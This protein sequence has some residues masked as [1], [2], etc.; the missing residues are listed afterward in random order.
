MR[1]ADMCQMAPAKGVCNEGAHHG[2]V[3]CCSLVTADNGDCCWLPWLPWQEARPRDA[4]TP[5]PHPDA[6][7]W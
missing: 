7:Y 6:H 3:L 4:Y 1:M 5:G 2:C